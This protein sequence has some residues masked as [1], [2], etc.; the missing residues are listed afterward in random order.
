VAEELWEY[1]ELK[2]EQKMLEKY[3]DI[4]VIECGCGNTI[5]CEAFTNHCTKCGTDYNFAGQILA[6][7]LH[8]GEETGE[9]ASEIIR[10]T[11]YHED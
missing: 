9:T 3:P 10:E 4:V 6:D 5:H 1:A 7:R 11:T 2:H 8:W